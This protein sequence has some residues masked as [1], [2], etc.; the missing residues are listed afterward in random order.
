MKIVFL[1]L[2]ALGLVAASPAA[3]DIVH[4]SVGQKLQRFADLTPGTHR[5]MRYLVHQDGSRQAVDIWDRRVS[6]EPKPDGSGLGMHIH[7]RWDRADKSSVLIQDSWFDAGTF[8]PLTH[9]RDTEKGGQT[10][11]WGFRFTKAAIVGLP[12]LAGN[13]RTSFSMPQSEP[14]YNFEYDMELLQTLSLAAGRTF[15]IPFY[16]AGIDSKP[17]RY[18]FV[19]AGSDRLIGPD[20]RPV[21]CWLVTADYNTGTIQSRFWFAKRGQLMLREEEVQNDGTILLKVVLPP[22]PMDG[23]A[24]QAT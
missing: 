13:Q 19:V 11:L 5:Y 17:D 16:D 10:T 12:S 4:L 20:G 22:E 8:R 6:F 24:A 2:V 14:H 7:Q 1:S 9:V 18:K 15:D 3:A 21:D 23:G